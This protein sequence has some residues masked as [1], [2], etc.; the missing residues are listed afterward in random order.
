MQWRTHLSWMTMF[1]VLVYACLC[2]NW[3][4]F[5][6]EDVAAGRHV[7][8]RHATWFD[9]AK[10]FSDS[11]DQAAWIVLVAVF[12][13]ETTIP[14]SLQ[15]SGAQTVLSILS[16][17]CYVV[18]FYAFVGFVGKLFMLLDVEPC[19]PSTDICKVPGATFLTATLDFENPLSHNCSL[20]M[21]SSLAK[22]TTNPIYFMTADYR[23]IVAL[24]G[25]DALNAATWLAILCLLQVEISFVLTTPCAAGALVLKTMSYCTVAA[26]IFI[27]FS[28]E[29][30]QDAWDAFLWLLAFLVIELNVVD[31]FSAHF[32][33]GTAFL[34]KF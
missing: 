31:T 7:L 5:F 6:E 13:L 18:L 1:K 34:K 26:G 17:V 10:V 27:W 25:I 15:A 23:R 32:P 16:G 30:Y 19:S 9:S 21:A 2:M 29:S 33:K 22:V 11:L 14:M 3:L 8:D 28:F 12:E 20:Y 4:S 24:L